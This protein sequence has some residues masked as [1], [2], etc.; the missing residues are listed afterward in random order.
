MR[1]LLVGMTLLAIAA[2]PARAAEQPLT[3]EQAVRVA[4]ANN[5]HLRAAAQQAEAARLDVQGAQT[6]PPLDVVA[7]PTLV[8]ESKDALTITQT[9]S[10][11]GQLQAQRAIAE[12]Q[13][14]LAGF[15]ASQR[16][17]QLRQQVSLAYVELQAAQANEGLQRQNL[18]LARRFLTGARAQYVAGNVPQANIIRAEIEVASAEQALGQAVM[19][20]QT[21]QSV[22]ARWLASPASG[23][24]PVATALG[25]TPAFGP[26]DR[27]IAEGL[28]DRPEL[29]Q[30]AVAIASGQAGVELLRAQWWPTFSASGWV[31]N[32]WAPLNNLGAA[33]T[34]EVLPWNYQRLPYQ[35]EAAESRVRAAEGTLAGWKQ[36]IGIEIQSAYQAW[37]LARQAATAI[38]TGV[39]ARSEKLLELAQEGFRLGANDYLV[40]IDAQR[41]LL[42]ARQNYLQALRNENV[43][44]ANLRL[45]VGMP[46]GEDP[47]R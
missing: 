26:L 20:R 28:A 43:A 39:L 5:A 21:Q 23:A 8:G 18:A 30:A 44:A 37:A 7:N 31:D 16:A 38:E 46:A 24:R 10:G 27:Y 1:A 29:R 17:Q 13:A 19:T 42:G 36:Q 40:V 14:E 45:A 35:L 4:L 6:L 34:V 47:H 9:L 22:L 12:R 25:H 33:V 11:W 2:A 15:T 3:L 32:Q 41:T